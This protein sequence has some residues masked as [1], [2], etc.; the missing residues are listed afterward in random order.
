MSQN[1]TSLLIFFQPFNNVK[2]I[3][4]SQAVQKQMAGQI[5]LQ[6]VVRPDLDQRH[7]KH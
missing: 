5:G 4:N 6:A 1:I 3:F 2:A 7:K